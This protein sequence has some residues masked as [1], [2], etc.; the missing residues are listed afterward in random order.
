MTVFICII[1]VSVTLK[2]IKKFAVTHN[3]TLLRMFII[4]QLVSV[5]RAVLCSGTMTLWWPTLEV[6][7]RCQII[8]F[9]KRVSC[10]WGPEKYRHNSTLFFNLGAIREWGVNAMLRRPH[11]R[12]RNPVPFVQE[13][14][15]AQGWAVRVCKISPPNRIRSPVRPGSASD[16][17]QWCEMWD[18]HVGNTVHIVS[19]QGVAF[20]FTMKEKH[21]IIGM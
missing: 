1:A 7:T 5:S 17:C 13:V 19:E 14:G 11:P 8:N 10:A 16:K 18:S 2:C 9:R 15:W 20:V 4:W 3:S 12:Q 6:E 21:S